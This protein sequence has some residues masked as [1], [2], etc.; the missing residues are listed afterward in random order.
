MP[1]GTSPRHRAQ[2]APRTTLD[3]AAR[4][5]G[6]QLDGA[7]RRTIA[8]AG[9]SGLLVSMLGGAASADGQS[10]WQ[11][12]LDTQA[13]T[14][15]VRAAVVTAPTVAVPAGATWQFDTPSFTVEADP[16][17]APVAPAPPT[18]GRASSSSS[19]TVG[20]YY[21]EGVPAPDTVAGNAVLEIAARYIGVPYVYGGSTPDGF[22]CS[23]FTSYVYAQL[24]ITLPRSS[25]AQGTVGTIV[26]A[27]QARPG[28]LMWW[29]GHVAIYAG[30]TIQIDASQPGTTVQFREI[31]RS[32]PT[33]IRVT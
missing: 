11:A 4:A 22:D 17:P 14:A 2:G 33:F 31:H 13:L 9:A 21:P 1:A 28:D 18:P 8:A 6:R 25:S 15:S 23:G 20:R 10:E 24:G 12:P 5:V 32:N 26:P 19:I 30:G 16:P 3:D 7:G 27:D 29:P